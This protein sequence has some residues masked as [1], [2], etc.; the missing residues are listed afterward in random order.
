[1][2]RLP[3]AQIDDLKV[4]GSVIV[5]STKGAK[6]DTVTAILL[7]ANADFL[8]QMAQGQASGG[9]SGMDAINRL[10][11]GMLAGPTGISLPTMLQ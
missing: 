9:E 7:L 2:E 8:V 3:A 1:M 5:T 6:S 11:G 4:G 10:H